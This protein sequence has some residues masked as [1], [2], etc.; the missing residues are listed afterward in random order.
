M[1]KIIIFSLVFL[2]TFVTFFLVGCQEPEVIVV[3]KEV[4]IK[5]TLTITATPEPKDT[6]FPNFDLENGNLLAYATESADGESFTL[7]F[8]DLSNYESRNIEEGQIELDYTWSPDGNTLAYRMRTGE[9]Q[10]DIFINDQESNQSYLLY[11][12]PN[13]ILAYS[14]APDSNQI[15]FLAP[16]ENYI[17]HAYL[18]R[19]DKDGSNVTELFFGKDFR[20]VIAP[21]VEWLESDIIMF[22]AH[23]FTEEG[24]Q[25]GVRTVQIFNYHYDAD[26]LQRITDYRFDHIW[27][28]VSPSQ[29]YI[30]FFSHDEENNLDLFLIDSVGQPL[31]Q[32]WSEDI[33]NP[34]WS[35]DS[36]QIVFA[37]NGKLNLIKL[38]EEI[39]ETIVE[40]EE[41]ED[42]SWSPDGEWIAFT[43]KSKENSYFQLY[44]VR[45]D[46]SE[47]TL[48][49]NEPVHH[50]N[51]SWQ[52]KIN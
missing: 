2:M 3:T 47:L 50:F 14:W 24:I 1:K 28:D 33:R 17:S 20:L 22:T 26:E 25:E 21:T 13:P 52:P 35:P 18:Y 6:P 39:V 5:E 23:V 38:E 11:D 46:G 7:N 19:V 15:A 27:P 30:M 16:D 34:D 4:V 41:V 8:F 12:H 10:K 29:E 49:T 36:K 45:N 31:A 9:N 37:D 51:P 44:I 42:P 48:L 40:M 43:G 32:L